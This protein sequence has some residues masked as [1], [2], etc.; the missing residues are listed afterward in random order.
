MNGNG[1][2]IKYFKLDWCLRLN[3]VNTKEYIILLRYFHAAYWVIPDH[4]PTSSFCEMLHTY[5]VH[6]HCMAHINAFSSPRT[7]GCLCLVSSPNYSVFSIIFYGYD[8]WFMVWWSL[9][10]DILPNCPMHSFASRASLII[11]NWW[12]CLF[13]KLQQHALRIGWESQAYFN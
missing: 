12:R 7:L 6:I 10:G 2:D 1:P 9:S 3:Q 4:C 5:C 8:R 11:I 13:W